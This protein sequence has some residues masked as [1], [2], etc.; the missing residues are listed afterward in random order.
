MKR[1]RQTPLSR[2]LDSSF[3]SVSLLV[4]QDLNNPHTSVCGILGLGEGSC[5]RRDLNN[6]HTSVCGILGFWKDYCCK[7]DLNNSQ[8]SVVDS[9]FLESVSVVGW[10]EKSPQ[11][12]AVEDI[13]KHNPFSNLFI[14][15]AVR[16]FVDHD[17]L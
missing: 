14:A 1:D 9:R 2:W 4:R 16:V 10:T 15:S 7:P 3:L 5:C 13:L 12:P 8:T 11:L 17:I 6:P